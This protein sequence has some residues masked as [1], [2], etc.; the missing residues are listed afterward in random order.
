M[1]PTKISDLFSSING[2]QS[3]VKADNSV[4]AVVIDSRKIIYPKST[5]FIA[6]K[7]AIIDGHEYIEDCLAK[8]VN[9]F[10]ISNK[11]YIPLIE[12]CNYLLVEDSLSS[13]QSMASYYKSMFDL[14]TIAI[15]GS[16]GKTIVKEWLSYMLIKDHRVAKSPGSFNSQIGVPLSMF[17]INNYHTIGVFEAGISKVDEMGRLRDIIKPQIGIFTN[18][19]EA[20][21]GGF[22]DK[23][24]KIEEKLLLFDNVSDLIIC[25]DHTDIKVKALDLL[26][27]ENI[28]IHTWGYNYGASLFHVVSA[29]KGDTTTITLDYMGKDYTFDINVVDDGSIENLLHCFAALLVLQYKIEDCIELTREIFPIPSRLEMSLGLNECLI[30]NDAYNHD[31]NSLQN[32]LA[33][34]QK[35]VGNKKSLLIL[36]DI[37]ESGMSSSVLSD[38]IKQLLQP[39]NHNNIWWIG[40]QGA[41]I[42][43]KQFADIQGLKDHINSTSIVDTCI[44]IKGAR[45]YK[46]DQLKSMLSSQRHSTKLTIDL[47]ALDHNLQVYARHLGPECGVIAVIKAG[48][49]GSG[50]DEL[51]RL[52]QYRGVQYLAVAFIDE[53]IALRKAGVSIPIMILNPETDSYYQLQRYQL[54]PEIYSIDQ[55]KAL[56]QYL[57]QDSYSSPIHLK[58][59]T[60]MNRLGLKPFEIDECIYLIKGNDVTVGTI[61]SHM[62][63]SENASEDEYSKRQHALFLQMSDKLVSGIGYRPKLH[64]VNTGGIVRFPQFH[65]DL[66][67]LG[68]GLYGID[69]TKEISS[70]LET[71]HTFTANVIQTKWVSKGEKIGYNQ[72][73]EA[74]KKTNLAIVN[75]GYAD[76]L[77]RSSGQGHYSLRVN[78]HDAPIIGNVCMDLTIIDITD[79]D[80]CNVGDQVEI[81][82]PNK[83][84]E[85]LSKVNNTIPYEILSRISPR[86]KKEWILG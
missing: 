35:Q 34:M 17:E 20:H 33:F 32:A 11:D 69:T 38:S 12:S 55:L 76:G 28:V 66:V 47:A 3:Q 22:M 4:S 68:I 84:I 73:G 58:L 80:T 59:D 39:Y 63:G 7:G 50:S 21:S 13:L 19:G 36:S 48:A 18:I 44:L 60:G 46:L 67:R 74:T 40:S 77:P 15:T 16:N 57:K 53:G 8:G 54:E 41:D 6:F 31:L 82:G 83:P 25:N 49:Y 30:I 45:R 5:L 10:I 56:V 65:H 23:S 86:V 37:E 43:D 29:D 51:A 14:I 78:G 1:Q 27:S 24:R 61:F 85:I 62:S 75:V 2:L 72:K 52:L 79:C 70:M 81:F 71:V 64:F 9:N 26:S 42:A